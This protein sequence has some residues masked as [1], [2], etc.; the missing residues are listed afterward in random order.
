MIETVHVVI[1]AGSN[2]GKEIK[3]LYKGKELS[4]IYYMEFDAYPSALF[5][6]LVGDS[7]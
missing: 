3:V 4:G 2:A 6:D 7:K 5:K 1:E